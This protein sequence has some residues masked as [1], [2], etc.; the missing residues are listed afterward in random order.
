MD[1]LA[2]GDPDPNSLFTREFLPRLRA[3]LTL[4]RGFVR[5]RPN[6]ATR[7]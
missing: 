6:C 4:L 3:D 7:L 1:R 2:A 5:S